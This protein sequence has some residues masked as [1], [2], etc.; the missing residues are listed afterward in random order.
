MRTGAIFFCALLFVVAGCAEV[1]RPSTFP[2]SF[3]QQLQSAS[4]WELIAKSTIE[5]LY[6]GLVGGPDQPQPI[7]VQSSDKSPFGRAFRTYLITKLIKSGFKIS[8]SPD[9]SI[10]VNWSVQ[11]IRRNAER[12]KPA[13]PGLH[14]AI[15]TAGWTAGWT[16][17]AFGH[18]APLATYAVASELVALLMD[19]E[20]NQTTTDH[21]VPHTELIL[22]TT[23]TGTQG[24]LAATKTYYINDQDRNNYW[25]SSD[26][27]INLPG[28][29][30]SDVSKPVTFTVVN[31]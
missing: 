11:L 29:F 9:K 26:I 28:T 24:I 5:D 16:A 22:T 4:H 13:L 20:L 17:R 12:R 21:K 2:Y 18:N 19:H 7:Y 30:T 31:R 6:T 23:V 3:Q 8:S 25:A 27:S 15:A 14:N 10:S 1:P